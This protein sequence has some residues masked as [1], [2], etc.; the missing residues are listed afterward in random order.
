MARKPTRKKAKAKPSM[1][2]LH[3]K[4]QRELLTKL[5]PTIKK[6]VRAHQTQTRVKV[7]YPVTYTA[8]KA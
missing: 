5:Q 2:A 3:K 1:S 8:S 4:V 7:A 6:I